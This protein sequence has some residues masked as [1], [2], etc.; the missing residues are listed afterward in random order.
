MATKI[1]F[2]AGVNLKYRYFPCRCQP[3]VYKA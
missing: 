1:K 2:H 3:Q